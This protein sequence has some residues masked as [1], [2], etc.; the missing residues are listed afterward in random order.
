VFDAIRRT[1]DGGHQV[2][3]VYPLVEESEKSDL[4][5]ATEMA[6]YLQ[7]EMFPDLH[8]GLLHGRM[9]SSE[10]ETVMQS[11]SA[12]EVQ[13]LVSTTVIEVGVD[14][15][16]ATLMVVEHAERFGLAQLHQL[17]GRVGRGSVQSLCIL[18]GDAGDSPEARRRLE[19][20]CETNDGFKIAEVDLELRGPGEMIGTRQS[21]V[22][23]FKYA[24]VIRDRRALELARVEANR[25]LQLLRQRPDQESR[26][27]AMFIRQQWKDRFGLALT[28]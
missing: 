16:N 24:N 25:F 10:K 20:M 18:A 15:P 5:A 4:R 7:S 28:G 21:G 3:V 19:I 1:V 27:V 8:I 17:R 13:V 6:K 2:Y 12:G 23:A 11:F 14:V 9:K 26:R 22:P